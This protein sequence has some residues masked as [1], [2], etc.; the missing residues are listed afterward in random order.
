MSKMRTTI[1]ALVTAGCLV[2]L[3]VEGPARAGAA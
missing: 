2:G 1:V 3:A